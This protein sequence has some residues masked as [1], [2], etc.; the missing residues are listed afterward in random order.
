MYWGALAAGGVVIYYGAGGW[1]ACAAGSCGANGVAAGACGGAGGCGSM[2]G[3]VS[4]AGD[5]EFNRILLTFIVGSVQW[6]WRR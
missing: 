1:A 5:R 3:G 4:L 6:R 2:S